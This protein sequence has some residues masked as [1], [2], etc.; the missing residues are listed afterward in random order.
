MPELLRGVCF[1]S[2]RD[3]PDLYLKALERLGVYICATYKK[4]ADLEIC[5]KA[6]ELILPEE[7]ILPE[8]PMAHQPKIWDVQ[9]MA[10]IKNKDTLR[11]DMRSLYVVMMSL[12]DANMKEKLKAHEGYADIKCTRDTLKLLQVIKQYMYKNGSEELHTIHNQVMSTIRLFW[13][14]QEKGQ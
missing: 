1:T 2:A 6:D 8:N 11:Q 7:P 12:C 5:L 13:M 4:G 3:G 14:R 9:M 10:M